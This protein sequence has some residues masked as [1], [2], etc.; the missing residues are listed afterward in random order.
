[1][2]SVGVSNTRRLPQAPC[3]FLTWV[4]FGVHLFVTWLW[5]FFL[6]LFWSQISC[7]LPSVFHYD[8]P[9]LMNISVLLRASSAV[10]Y[11]W[12]LAKRS[13]TSLQILHHCD[14]QRHTPSPD[15]FGTKLSVCLVWTGNEW[16]FCWFFLTTKQK[17]L[18]CKWS[19]GLSP[20]LW[21]KLDS[22]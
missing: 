6:I 10:L 22:F 19:L 1:M 12:S 18:A 8:S 9:N 7:G 13:H 20:A 3:H 4:L 21:S 15:Q 17:V 11:H 16:I 2:T 5:F 14:S